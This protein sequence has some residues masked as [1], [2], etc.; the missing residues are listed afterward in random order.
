M[1][2]QR[3]ELLSELNRTD[4]QRAYEAYCSHTGWKSLVSG[5]PL[6]KW[7]DLDLRIKDA[8]EAAAE[9]VMARMQ[10]NK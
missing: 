4:G 2:N 1:E 7:S 8:W 6:P 3:T 10:I 9:A 5:A